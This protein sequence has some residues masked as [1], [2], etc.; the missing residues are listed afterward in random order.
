MRAAL[1][2]TVKRRVSGGQPRGERPTQRPATGSKKVRCQALVTGPRYTVGSRVTSPPC[3]ALRADLLLLKLVPFVRRHRSVLELY[4][5]GSRTYL[6]GP[7]SSNRA[8]ATARARPHSRSQLYPF[9]NDQGTAPQLSTYEHLLGVAISAASAIISGGATR[10]PLHG[11]PRW[12]L[13]GPVASR[14]RMIDFCDDGGT[15]S[16]T[17]TRRRT[18]SPRRRLYLDCRGIY[19]A[20]CRTSLAFNSENIGRRGHPHF[21]GTGEWVAPS[22]P[23]LNLPT[24]FPEGWDGAASKVP[25][26][27]LKPA[28]SLK[29]R[30]Q[31]FWLNVPRQSRTFSVSTILMRWQSFPVKR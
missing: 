10:G 26:C 1:R 25:S 18:R 3:T 17:S 28:T 20:A 30:L 4:M 7:S 2:S 12:T 31:C 9:R 6:D 29:L 5:T 15:M 19:V 27:L 21:L 24:C 22:N 13:I 14:C 16:A 23:S 11:H 8:A